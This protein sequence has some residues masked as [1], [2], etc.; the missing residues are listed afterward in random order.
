M[1]PRLAQ[2]QGKSRQMMQELL[3]GVGRHDN[4]TSPVVQFFNPGTNGRD[5]ILMR[6]IWFDF[7]LEAWLYTTSSHYLALNLHPSSA[8]KCF[9]AMAGNL[10]RAR[11][12]ANY[13]QP[14]H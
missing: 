3:R 14:N 13:V 1:E 4:E 6:Y 12:A 8:L 11:R 7:H 9:C 5:V 2:T 10:R